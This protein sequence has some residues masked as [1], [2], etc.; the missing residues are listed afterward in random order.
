MSLLPKSTGPKFTKYVEKD[1]DNYRESYLN[2]LTSFSLE[3]TGIVCTPVLLVHYE[4]RMDKFVSVSHRCR[5]FR[6]SVLYYLDRVTIC[7]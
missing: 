2:K 6:F 4:I 3:L 7:L 5:E 1:L